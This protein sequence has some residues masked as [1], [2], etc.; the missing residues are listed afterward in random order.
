[1]LT[2][3]VEIAV[4]EVGGSTY[5]VPRDFAPK[6]LT[7]VS[8][9]GGKK[10]VLSTTGR[11]VLDSVKSEVSRPKNTPIAHYYKGRHLENITMNYC[12]AVGLVLNNILDAPPPE[13]PTNE[14]DT[15]IKLEKKKHRAKRSWIC[16]P[17]TS[18]FANKKAKESAIDLTGDD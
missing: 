16:S 10:C 1:M 17:E 12:T 14:K 15:E 18:S 4:Y 9:L 13:Q 3:K 2:G 6:K 11:H 5:Q 8:K 7:A